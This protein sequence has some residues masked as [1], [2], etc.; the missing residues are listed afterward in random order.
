MNRAIGVLGLC[1]IACFVLSACGGGGTSSTP[2]PPENPSP[3][4]SGITPNAV[5]AGAGDT[6]VTING[7]GF[8]GSST[9]KWNATALSTNFISATKLTAVVPAAQLTGS[10]TNQI[11][12]TNPAPGGG[13]SG[14]TPFTV[15]SPVAAITG[16][17][18]RYVPPGVPETVTVTGTGFESNSVVMW[19]GAAKPTTFVN[20]TT[21]T[22]ALTASD[23]QNQGTGSLTVSNPGPGPSTSGPAPLTVTS[24]PIPVIQSVSVMN[25]QGGGCAGLQVT[26]TGQN[27]AYDST[28]QANGITLPTIF[29][30]PNP[31]TLVDTLPAGFTSAP[32]GLTFT[33]TNPDSGPIVSNPYSYPAA[34]PPVLAL[35]ATPSPTTVYAGSSFSLHVQPSEVNVGGNA[36][37]ALGTL[38]IGVTTTSGSVAL[39][40]TGVTLHLSAANSIAAGTYDLQLNGTAGPATAT[41]DFNF[42]VSTGAPP[43][44]FFSTPIHNEVGVPI[45]GSGSIQYQSIVNTGSG[46]ADYDVT[47]SVSGLPPG[48]TAAFTPSVFA[49]GESVTVTLSAASTA[50][51]TQNALV[52]LTGT[53]TS[54]AVTDASASFYADVTQPPGSLPGNRTD[55]VSI[56]GTPYAAVYDAT[57]N[58]IF[59]SNPDW[60]RV[61]VISNSSHKVVKSVPIRSPR[62][63]DITQDDGHV[64]VQ[65]ASPSL[66]EIDTTSLQ[67]RSFSLPSMLLASSGGQVNINSQSNRLLALADGTL[68]IYFNDGGANA[69]IPEIWDP[70]TNKVTI[71]TSVP[72][73]GIGVPMRSGDGTHVYASYSSGTAVY[74]VGSQSL[75]LISSGT[76]DAK[77]VGV[78]R[79]GS[80]LV[81]LGSFGILTLY[82][83]NL[84]LIGSLPG[85]L[86]ISGGAVFSGD[87]TKLY[88]V[89]TYNNLAAILSVNASSLAVSGTAP[90]SFSNIYFGS[91]NNASP[92]PVPFAIDT[93]GMVLAIQ[94]YGVSFEDSTFY[95]TYAANQPTSSG[96][97]AGPT[98]A[99]GPLAGGTT[100]SLYAFPALQPDVWFGQMRGSTSLLQGQLT[101]TSPPSQTPGP[102]NVKFIYPDGEQAFYPQLFGYSTFPEYALASGSSPNGGAT[103]Q[104]VGYGL[105][106]DPSEGTLAVGGNT[107]I[108]T[109][110]KGQYPPLSGEPYPSTI[111]SYTIPAGAPGLADLQVSSSAN[112]TGSL[113]KAILYAKSVNDYSSSD[114]FAAVIHDAKRKQ[115]YLSAGDHVDVFSLDS[116]QF[117][118][119]LHPAANGSTK[120]FAGLALTPDGS[121]L[122]VTDLLDGSLAV[123][124]PDVPATTFAI[125]IAPATID[126][127]NNCEVGPLYVAAASGN[128]A[129]VTYGSLPATSCYVSGS[130]YVVNLQSRAVTQPSK[131]SGGVSAAANSDGSLVAIGE[132]AGVVPCLY[133]A[134]DSSYTLGTAFGAP[135]GYGVTISGDG[136]VIGE[137]LALWDASL[138]IVGSISQPIGLYEGLYS[139]AGP[140]TLLLHPLL[141]ASGSLY[142]FSY[143]NY[144][145][146]AD[147]AHGLL[148][149]RFPL[150]ETIQSTIMPMAIDS[151]GRNIFLITDKGLTVVDLGAALLSIGHL[152]Q[153]NAGPGTQVTVR[154]SGFDSTVT[155]KVGGVAATVKV[156]DENTLTLTIPSASSGSEDIALSRGDGQTYTL[157]NAVV[158]P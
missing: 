135:G 51:V 60:N 46:S 5:T 146:I 18:P 34:M 97:S 106:Q 4:V 10:S 15:N 141:N 137:N 79:D 153:Q 150:T 92:T 21:L 122:L 22:V 89:T 45:G 78:N 88:E 17:S 98:P 24:Q 130:L 121:E 129:F 30:G 42:T 72:T 105:P 62:G 113:P 140:S 102:V 31:T 133:S 32:S 104:V 87:G 77:V 138:N 52:G 2:P 63:I 101:F 14:E 136:N 9:A 80:R 16:I 111:L 37:L 123:I 41:A 109:T 47:P 44:F 124:N 142:F 1:G 23:L 27:F 99:S 93:T 68:L 132:S 103:G 143:P 149:M 6:L 91:G 81:L 8:I 151:G 96:S 148:R 145:E 56:A 85:K 134:Q 40:A 95:Q 11:T 43:S 86:S 71:I 147:V 125:A 55:F 144:F 50:P 126:T 69:G 13:T 33:V 154:G 67:A 36:N 76:G 94:T 35:C 115:V 3:G 20:A 38:P 117:V 58:L 100:S 59:A 49:A 155:A 110:V 127:A 82:D 112:G 158:L 90:S 116:N 61:Y 139:N 12:V 39:P 128:L 28:I 152:S 66:Y 118:A 83:N 131:C 48:T 7:S 74:T 156:T 29:F 119:P 57:H 73:T 84:N 54:A 65:T 70:Q 26:V 157:E 53:P 108:I 75:R 114:T 107:A 120:Q 19:N 64:W 25:V